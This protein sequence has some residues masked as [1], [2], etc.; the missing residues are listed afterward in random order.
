MK[1]MS[2]TNNNNK[3]SR[4]NA[5]RRIGH[6]RLPAPLCALCALCALL[7]VC[8]GCGPSAP[9]EGSPSDG[10]N[11]S[12]GGEKLSI[13]ATV[14][15]EYDWIRSVL[16]QRAEDVDLTLLLD[17]GVDLHSYQP[18]AGD[19]VMISSCDLFVYVGGESDGWVDGVLG[20]AE[21]DGRKTL[22]LLDLLGDRAKEEEIAEGMEAEEEEAEEGE[23]EGP[24]YDEHVWLSLKNAVLFT[25]A[26]RDALSALDSEN[27]DE[28][29]GNA[30]AYIE[31]LR[32]LDEKYAAAAA[33]AEKTVLLFAD[34]FPFRYLTDDYGLDYY[35]A[36]AGCS[37][38]S[39]ASFE[40]VAFLADRIGELGLNN[41]I[42][43]E[44]GNE[45]LA[46][47]VIAASGTSGAEGEIGI[48]TMNSM[49]SVTASDVA[50]GASYLSI[51]ESNLVSL[52]EAL[53]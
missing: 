5:V 32:A 41:V 26:I 14:F 23:E 9:A 3:N 50:S 37:A 52:R 27:A 46:Q 53:R 36:F 24:E 29:A 51:M 2:L 30:A 43:L 38:E 48:V 12:A 8:A 40:T 42:I 4:A 25:E 18:T 21:A 49:Q 45:R 34:R 39:E 6:F 16:G 20:E 7:L 35:A 19:I 28:Y 17:T 11:N 1:N 13:V 10:G 15:P 33:E 31:K 22:C 44:G 47:T